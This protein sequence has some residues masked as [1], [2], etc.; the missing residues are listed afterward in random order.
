MRL[1][2]NA[3][4]L[5]YAGGMDTPEELRWMR[6][7]AKLTQPELGDALGHDEFWVSRREKGTTQIGVDDYR[8][9]ASACGYDAVVF[10]APSSRPKSDEAVELGTK[11]MTAWDHLTGPAQQMLR[12]VIEAAIR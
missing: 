7:Q 10:A 6:L 4:S 8:D 12:A 9:W 11:L 3:I 2:L 5:S 1:A